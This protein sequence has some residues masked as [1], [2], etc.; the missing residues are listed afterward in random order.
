MVASPKWALVTGGA[1]AHHAW[2]R[3]AQSIASLGCSDPSRARGPSLSKP[4]HIQ[5]QS[6][7]VCSATRIPAPM[8]QQPTAVWASTPPSSCWHQVAPSSSH[9]ATRPRVSPPRS[10]RPPSSGAA[11]L[12]EVA[13]FAAAGTPSPYI[14]VSDACM[15][16]IAQVLRRSP[17]H[18]TLTPT[19]S[20]WHPPPTMSAALRPPPRREGRSGAV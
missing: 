8:T 1:S 12:P 2:N 20:T 18:I 13:A 4:H 3:F 10:L 14:Q 15:N 17:T 9:R 11:G 6:T 16:S 7:D 5:H 19:T